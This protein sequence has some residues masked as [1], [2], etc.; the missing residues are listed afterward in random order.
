[1]IGTVVLSFVVA[2]SAVFFVAITTAVATAE[3]AVVLALLLRLNLRRAAAAVHGGAVKDEAFYYAGCDDKITPFERL[4]R[5]GEEVIQINFKWSHAE[6]VR[7]GWATAC[8]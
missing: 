8:T 2:I 6:G 4:G 5:R 7:D 1:M 3:H